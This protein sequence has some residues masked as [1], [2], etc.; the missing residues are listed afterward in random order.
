MLEVPGI[1]RVNTFIATDAAPAA[2]DARP[3]AT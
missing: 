2:F 1:Q 3:A